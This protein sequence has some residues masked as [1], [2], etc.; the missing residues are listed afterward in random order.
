[1]QTVGSRALTL[2]RSRLAPVGF[3]ELTADNWR[4]RDPTNDAFARFD[5]ATGRAV[6]L[7][8]DEWARHFL[9]FRLDQ[10]V[11]DEVRDLFAVAQGT[12]LYGAF[13][14]PLYTL[15]QEQVHRVADAAAL[16]RY[17]QLGGPK[18]KKGADPPF[19][20]RIKWLV[21]KAAIPAAEQRRWNAYRELR[22]I[23]SHAEFQ[24]LH[25]PTEA[26]TS[27]RVVAGS[28]NQLFAPALPERL[29]ADE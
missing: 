4:E 16:H 3:K 29:T 11:P 28:V 9:G 7:S 22:N 1:M 18:T 14:Y 5:C 12:M 20:T 13:F 26:L 24:Q 2:G 21:Q 10:R 27:L 15:G 23:G 8:P 25:L 19:A 17:Y 6:A